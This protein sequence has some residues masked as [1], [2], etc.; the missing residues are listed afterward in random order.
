MDIQ[1]I[2]PWISDLASQILICVM[3]MIAFYLVKIVKWIMFDN[4][5]KLLRTAGIYANYTLFSII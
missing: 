4:I 1:V 3:G 2:R 5:S